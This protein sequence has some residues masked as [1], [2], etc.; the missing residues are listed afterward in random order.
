KTYFFLA[1]AGLAAAAPASSASAFLPDFLPMASLRLATF[2]M[3]RTWALSSLMRPWLLSRARRS[4]RVR[5]LRWR[6][7]PAPDFR[8]GSRLMV[9]VRTGRLVGFGPEL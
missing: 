9:V 5:T 1:A 6:L 7:R 4:V 3:A 8:L 2:G